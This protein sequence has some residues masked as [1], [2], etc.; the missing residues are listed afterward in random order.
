MDLRESRGEGGLVSIQLAVDIQVS[1]EG[2]RTLLV[3]ME[4]VRDVLWR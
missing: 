3:S 2:A 1:G 4:W